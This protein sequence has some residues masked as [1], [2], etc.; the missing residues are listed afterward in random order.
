[1]PSRL[2]ALGCGAETLVYLLFVYLIAVLVTDDRV[3]CATVDA[4]QA[5]RK[6]LQERLLML[7]RPQH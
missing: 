6:D 5:E 1:M 2:R 7:P 3:C 4:V